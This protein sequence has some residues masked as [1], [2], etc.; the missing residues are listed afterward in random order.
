[1]SEFSSPGEVDQQFEEIVN[2]GLP[3]IDEDGLGF[4]V[5]ERCW[6]CPQL[7]VALMQIAVLNHKIREIID[8]A[9]AVLPEN[10]EDLS[11]YAANDS[12]REMLASMDEEYLEALATY[13][14]ES[15]RRDAA[16]GIEELS[17]AILKFRE[18][19]EQLATS[20]AGVLRFHADNGEVRAEGTICGSSKLL[21]PGNVEEPSIVHR[22]C[23]DK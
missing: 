15:Y 3:P 13:L 1:M 20:C 10:G 9:M 4:E 11:G 2:S 18:M 5:P 17:K 16:D 7:Y 6:S 22:S 23:S 14:R 19:S 21:H 8:V 12:A